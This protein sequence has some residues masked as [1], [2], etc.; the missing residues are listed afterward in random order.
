MTLTVRS[1]LYDI[2]YDVWYEK[3]KGGIR[4]MR[5]IMHYLHWPDSGSGVHGKYGEYAF[6]KIGM[7]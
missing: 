7:R 1:R 2:G 5:H 4:A 6:E 3:G